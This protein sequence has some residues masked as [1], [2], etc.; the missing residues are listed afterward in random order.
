M[1]LPHGGPRDESNHYPGAIPAEDVIRRLF[2]FEVEDQPI[3]LANSV[4]IPNRKAMVRSDTGDVFG[5][6]KGGYQG[7]A[8]EEWL[9]DN[10]SS[11]LDDDLQI[12]S[13]GLLKLG[14]Q[15]W[16]SIE[17]PENCHA[18]GLIP[19]EFGCLHELRRLTRYD[20]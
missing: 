15:A 5:I 17:M 7:H 14:A 12:G 3:Y 11:V 16:V 1:A 13:S 6:F 9:L 20:V 19:A 18:E 2:N 10:V 8:Y 4:E